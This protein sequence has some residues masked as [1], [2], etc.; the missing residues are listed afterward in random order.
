[1][2]LDWKVAALINHQDEVRVS[3]IVD[4]DATMSYPFRTSQKALRL[5]A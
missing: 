1:M 5:P 4:D 3:L 2:Q